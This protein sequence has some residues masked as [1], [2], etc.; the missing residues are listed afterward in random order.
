M[1]RAK[2]VATARQ[3]AVM[4]RLQSLFVARDWRGLMDLDER[5]GAISAVAHELCTTAPLDAVKIYV[6]LGI[7]NLALHQEDRAT[8]F[9]L[10]ANNLMEDVSEAELELESE[11]V[12]EIEML[13]GMFAR[14]LAG[15][16][17]APSSRRNFK[18]V[19]SIREQLYLNALS[20]LGNTV[21]SACKPTGH[22]S[23]NNQVVASLGHVHSPQHEAGSVAIESNSSRAQKTEEMDARLPLEAAAGRDIGK[24]FDLR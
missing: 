5:D 17:A 18:N 24:R 21:G 22:F 15:S 23:K 9:C 6:K 14:Q 2:A 8:S 20:G 12:E 1:R 13:A 19:H 16:D 3:T 11:S 4:D 10:E 7:C